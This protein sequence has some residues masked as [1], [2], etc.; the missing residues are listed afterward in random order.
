MKKFKGFFLGM[1]TMA[2]IVALVV[3]V[4]AAEPKELT[5]YFG[6]IKISLDGQVFQPK[7]VDGN[8]VEPFIVDGTTYLPVRA[9]ATA[10]GMNVDWDGP[11]QTVLLAHQ[12]QE[13][14]VYI[15]RT[16]SKYHYDS[17]CNGGTY[18]PIS[19]SPAVAMGYRPCDKCVNH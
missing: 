3:T 6:G 10:L 8:P 14:T 19:L 15:T 5:A 4:F 1:L 7:T 9:V 2:L 13:Q 12:Q 18:Y 16:G 11:N 17:T